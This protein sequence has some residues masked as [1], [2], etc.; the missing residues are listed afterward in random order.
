M[1]DF[2]IAYGLTYSEALVKIEEIEKLSEAYR[3]DKNNKGKFACLFSGEEYPFKDFTDARRPSWPDNH[4]LWVDNC[5]RAS[6]S[7][8]MVGGGP[9][10][11]FILTED[12]LKAND[13]IVDSWN[14]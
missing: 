1:N 8:G 6:H 12:D 13:W 10:E 2:T 14:W 11:R 7:G 4:Y 3:E 9:A 5:T